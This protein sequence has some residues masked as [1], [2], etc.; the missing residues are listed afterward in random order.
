M[1]IS[2]TLSVLTL[3]AC[4][5]LHAQAPAPAKKASAPATP[6]APAAKKA[7]AAPAKPAAPKPDPNNP[8]VLTIGDRQI[9]KNEFEALAAALPEP[10]KTSAT[11]PNKRKFVE[12][13]AD[14]E[15][16]AY[17]ARRRQMDQKPGT[18]LMMALQADNVLASELFKEINA[19]VK[20]DD[21]A[22]QAYFDQHKSEY[23][24]VKAS[25]I[26]IRFKGSPVPVK[27]N[28][29]DLTEEE[30]LAKAK[31]I[32]EKLANGGDFVALAKA[33]SDDAGSGAQGG[34][35][36]QFGHGQMV[37]PFDQAAF[38]LPVGQVS[39][40]VK[41]QFGYHLIKVEEHKSRSFDEVKP[42]VESKIKPEM[43]KKAVD[44]VKK[45]VKVVIDE[46]Y[47]GK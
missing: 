38:S 46:A 16:M 47:F 40:P 11:G 32:R 43:A 20:V 4:S 23:E 14:M 24:Q 22:L 30:A 9:T 28:Q 2:T 15:A 8:V 26:L 1:R 42:Q 7:A 21:A 45:T 13:Y 35:L 3:S 6:A 41:T 5:L 39:E 29:K 31:E 10:M 37:A 27:A 12:Q 18:K 17:E 34:V 36:G 44:D 33:E 19:G 25:H